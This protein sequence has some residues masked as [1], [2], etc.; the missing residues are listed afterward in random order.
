[1]ASNK[2]G[3][4]S[5]RYKH[6]TESIMISREFCTIMSQTPTVKDTISYCTPYLT[7]STRRL[8]ITTEINMS[9]VYS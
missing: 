6:E 4:S 8:C 5:I 2:N 7:T 3:N 1:M 9:E